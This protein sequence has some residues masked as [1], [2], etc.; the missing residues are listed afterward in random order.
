MLKAEMLK[1]D[2]AGMPVNPGREPSRFAV[3]RLIRAPGKFVRPI[4]VFQFFSFS[5]F[6]A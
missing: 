1:S 5:A 3:R 4:S 2:H 6:S